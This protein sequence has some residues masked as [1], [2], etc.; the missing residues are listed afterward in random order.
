MGGL[1][2]RIVFSLKIK[3]LWGAKGHV[4]GNDADRKWGC[5]AARDVAALLTSGVREPKGQLQ[6]CV[7]LPWASLPWAWDRCR[8]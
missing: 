4:A 5:Q 1:A 7:W 3:T 2:S 6:G 8:P